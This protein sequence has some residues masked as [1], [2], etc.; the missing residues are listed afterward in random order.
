[1][2]GVVV[3]GEKFRGGIFKIHCARLLVV[4]PISH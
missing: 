4:A 1:M 3:D 2:V